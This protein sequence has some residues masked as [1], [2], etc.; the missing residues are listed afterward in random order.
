MHLK[1]PQ[2]KANLGRSCQRREAFK[3][4]LRYSSFSYVGGTFL[5]KL[6]IGET[7]LIGSVPPIGGCIASTSIVSILQILAPF[8]PLHLV[9]YSIPLKTLLEKTSNYKIN[10]DVPIQGC[11]VEAKKIV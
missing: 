3:I 4:N 9:G 6:F 8:L 7:I 1:D 2:E 10:K 11:F 5:C